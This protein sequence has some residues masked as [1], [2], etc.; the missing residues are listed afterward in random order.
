[1]SL[2]PNYNQAIIPIEKFTE[3]ALNPNKDPNKA[4]AFE[5][6]LGYNLRNAAVLIENIRRNL[7]QF[8]AVAK[9]NKGYGMTY[10]II[11][12]LTGINGKTAKVKTG[13]IHDDVNDEVRLVTAF[14]DK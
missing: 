5:S 2:L 6:A 13:W 11:M 1:V 4:D 8:P 7:S 14:V 3:Y 9:D 10:E 12:Q